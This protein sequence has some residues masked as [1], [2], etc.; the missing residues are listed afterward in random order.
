MRYVARDW[1]YCI[2]NIF[3]RD[4]IQYINLA[5]ENKSIIIIIIV[6]VFCI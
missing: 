4:P 2:K 5:L 1:W 3:L 6:A